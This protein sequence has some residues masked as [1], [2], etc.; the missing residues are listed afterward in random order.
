MAGEIQALGM[1]ASDYDWLLEDDGRGWP[2]ENVTAVVDVSET[3]EAKWQ[4]LHCH[5]TQFGPGNL[6]RRLPETTVRQMMGRESFAQ[7]WPQPT[8]GVVATSLFE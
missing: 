8:S 1:D 4:A 2:D 3:V 6:F 5:R 7:A